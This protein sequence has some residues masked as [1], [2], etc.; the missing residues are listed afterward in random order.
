MK[1]FNI[2]YRCLFVILALWLNNTAQAQLSDYA[3]LYIEGD[4]ETPF[5]IKL[6]GKMMPRLAQNYTILSNLDAGVTNIEILFQ[7]NKYAP[8]RFA[9]NVPKQVGRGLMLRKVDDN[10]VLLDLLTNQYIFPGNKGKDDDITTLE[11]KYY[12]TRKV[13]FGNN[14]T[15]AAQIK[16]EQKPVVK[17]PKEELP[18]F[19]P[20]TKPAQKEKPEKVKPIKEKVQKEKE[21][22]TA[23]VKKQEA[24]T[25]SK[26]KPKYLD[27]V[28]INKQNN[29]GDDT[30]EE[31]ISS[32]S[33]V[34][35]GSCETPMSNKEFDI[36][37]EKLK[38]KEAEG[39]I[40]YI[41]KSKKHCF[42]TNQVSQIG[43]AIT[44][45]SGRLQILTQL[46]NQT[47]DRENYQSLEDLF[48]T[49]Y[50]KKKFID[51]IPK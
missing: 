21:E 50:L 49:E 25:T 44:S 39:R 14:N 12:N 26:V 31:T 33:D 24:E 10:F 6:E 17:T 30:E 20:N 2:F 4:K 23:V 35:A 37:L 7:Q 22:T 11:N 3:Y 9:I 18:A 41:Q 32:T 51:S 45:A 16:E 15:I 1:G 19:N 28:V 36:F 27:N 5:Y 38:S 8:V 13:T 42:S 40:K 43:K 34:I 29:V 47:T 48:K 46:Y